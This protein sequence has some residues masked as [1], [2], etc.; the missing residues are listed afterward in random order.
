[1]TS[2]FSDQVRGERPRVVEKFDRTSWDGVIALVGRGVSTSAFAEDFPCMCPDGNGPYACDAEN[3]HAALHAE[4]PDLP[5]Q[6]AAYQ[7]PDTLAILDLLQFIYRHASYA[8]RRDHHGFFGHHHLSFDRATGRREM[9]ERINTLLTRNGLAYELGEDGAITH[10]AAPVVRELLRSALPATGDPH[11]D[12]LL[13]RARMKFTHRD[14]GVRREA[15]E[16]A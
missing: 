6:F 15:L 3:F 7:V 13:E 5:A 11:L 4:I 16:P 9:R 10:I 8:T 2:Y 12:A 1:M 14:P